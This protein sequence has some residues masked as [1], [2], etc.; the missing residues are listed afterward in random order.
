[1]WRFIGK[2]L[3]K[4]LNIKHK[5]ERKN[6]TLRRITEDG[7]IID[8]LLIEENAGYSD[9]TVSNDKNSMFILYES[10]KIL[11]CCRVYK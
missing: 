5:R 4:N 6:L 11:K 2:T 9:V 7:R 10:E 8:S 3:F 1:M